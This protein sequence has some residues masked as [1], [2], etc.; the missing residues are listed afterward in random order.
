[1]L[2]VHR[3]LAAAQRREK[4]LIV[5]NERCASTLG[6]G[7]VEA[8]M[9]RVLEHHGDFERARQQFPGYNEE[10]NT[11]QVPDRL[12]GLHVIDLPLSRRFHSTLPTSARMRSGAISNASPF[13]TSRRAL[14]ESSSSRYHLQATLASTTQLTGD[15]DLRE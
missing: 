6:G 10:K 14:A 2:G 4:P 12:L 9:D 11:G 13:A 15:P 1:V 5:G 7:D 3:D 8:I